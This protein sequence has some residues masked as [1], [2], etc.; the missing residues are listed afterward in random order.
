MS[1]RFW[2]TA[3]NKNCA[4][5]ICTKS[6]QG[7]AKVLQNSFLKFN[8]GFDFFI[9]YI[10]DLDNINNVAVSITDIRKKYLSEEKFFEMAFKY[11]LTEFC[12]SIKPFSIQFFLEKGYELAVYLDPDI[13]FYSKF[14]E[15]LDVTKSIYITPHIVTCETQ[16]SGDDEE[17]NILR[18]GIYNCGFIAFRKTNISKQILEWWMYRL[19]DAC[20]AAP[21][22]GLFTDQ[23][24]IDFLP[25]LVSSDELFIIKNIGCNVAPWNFYEREVKKIDGLYKVYNRINKVELVT[26]LCFVHFSG[27][28]YKELCGGSIGHKWLMN[29]YCDILELIDGYREALNANHAFDFFSLQYYFA[30]YSDGTSIMKLH[31][32]IY[33]EIIKK[34]AFDHPFFVEEGFFLLLKKNKMISK[35]Q[36]HSSNTKNV[37]SFL[38][39]KNLIFLFFKLVLRFLGI[40][41][42]EEF[43]LGIHK[44]ST[45]NDQKN[46]L[47][48]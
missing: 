26:D 12:T 42:F 35:K 19:L 44:Y 25:A 24:W 45:L 6:Y 11:D 3:M 23:K 20:Y 14:E 27:F 34:E 13:C 47:S 38:K 30:N 46:L 32:R 36:I 17:S 22:Y 15:I 37:S 4:F 7:L 18:Y 2:R 16:Y 33:G 5:T 40:D 10:D 28:N 31:R 29:N 41:R 39:K 9:I 21:E 43:I 1:N 48:K 8:D